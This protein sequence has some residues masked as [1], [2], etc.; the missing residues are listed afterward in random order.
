MTNNNFIDIRWVDSGLSII[1]EFFTISC[2]VEPYLLIII[3]NNTIK[4][5]GPD[6]SLTFIYF[7]ISLSE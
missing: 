6:P 7:T 3:E 5:T 4:N 1:F 2:P